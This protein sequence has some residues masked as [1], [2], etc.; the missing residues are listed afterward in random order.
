M[1]AVNI[2]HARFE[3][4]VAHVLVETVY[5]PVGMSAREARDALIAGEVGRRF[6]QAVSV[7]KVGGAAFTDMARASHPEEL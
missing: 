6:G 1:P 7:Y 2:T 4:R 3:V 5:L